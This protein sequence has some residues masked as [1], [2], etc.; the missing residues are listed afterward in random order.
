MEWP[1]AGR[2]GNS[3]YIG[4]P[5]ELIQITQKPGGLTPDVKLDEITFLEYWEHG[6][7]VPKRQECELVKQVSRA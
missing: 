2:G 4:G 7:E 5:A 6:Y 3:L 1:L